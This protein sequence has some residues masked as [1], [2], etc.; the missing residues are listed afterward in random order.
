MN[1]P[2]ADNDWTLIPGFTNYFCNTSGQIASKKATNYNLL[3]FVVRDKQT[4]RLT[5]DG[6]TVTYDVHNLIALTFHPNP[7]NFEFVKHKNGES[8]DNHSDNLEWVRKRPDYSSLRYSEQ[9]MR[10]EVENFS[11]WKTIGRYPNYYFHPD[12]TIMSV[13][14]RVITMKPILKPKPSLIITNNEGEKEMIQIAFL[15]ATAFIPNELGYT[16]VIEIDGNIEN[17]K[18]SNLRWDE[19]SSTTVRDHKSKTQD[20]EM[21]KPIHPYPGYLISRRGEVLSTKTKRNVLLTP[22]EGQAQTSYRIRDSTGEE[23][24]TIPIQKL[25]GL[26]FIPNPYNY[27]FIAPINGDISDYDLDNLYWHPNPNGSTEEG[28]IVIEN[29]PNYEVSG[30]GVRNKETKLMLNPNEKSNGDYP[31]VKVKNIKGKTQTVYIHLLI[32]R[33]LIPNPNN[34]PVANHIDG[35]HYNYN[36]SNLEWCTHSENLKHAYDT[37]LRDGSTSVTMTP[38]GNEIWKTIEFAPNYQV[39]NTGIVRNINGKIRKLRNKLGY[40][41]LTL[42]TPDKTKKY[43]YVHRLVAFAFLTTDHL[44]NPLDPNLVYEVNHKNKNPS[45]NRL[46]NLEIM[47]VKHHRQKDQGKAVI[48]IDPITLEVKEFKTI[49]QTAKEMHW[50]VKT[51]SKAIRE[52][53]PRTG[54]YFFLRDDPDLEAKIEFVCELRQNVLYSHTNS[55]SK[56]SP[57]STLIE[58]LLFNLNLTSFYLL[59]LKLDVI[60]S[61]LIKS[62]Q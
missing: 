42:V 51:I 18:A 55:I 4:V 29:F 58:H 52:Q 15:I 30:F 48:A 46:E 61:C 21:W 22:I 1:N 62:S 36:I 38:T 59:I 45:D 5:H 23:Q 12:G 8:W 50:S 40:H 26:A 25:L 10:K 54:W 37:G 6:K 14:T 24:L 13:S 60:T 3:T 9:K 31:S 32:A 53:E 33:N 2:N 43:P 56:P 35:N 27:D 41:I 17:A 39:S 11:E 57:H 7:N 44:G 28:W 47:S 49:S 19:N 34:H 20:T 16:E